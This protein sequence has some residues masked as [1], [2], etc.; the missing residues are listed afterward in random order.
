MMNPNEIKLR[1]F[2]D[3]KVLIAELVRLIDRAS[4]EYNQG[5]ARA[6]ALK[7]LVPALEELKAAGWEGWEPVAGYG[8]LIENLLEV[9]NRD[10]VRSKAVSTRGTFRRYL[11][12]SVT[13]LMQECGLEPKATK[14]GLFENLSEVVLEACGEPVGGLHR[15][16][17]D[18]KKNLKKR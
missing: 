15:I 14:Y 7:K 13:V 9:F 11:V 6:K 1:R 12:A 17:R 10:L 18:V 4:V 8:P 2:T 3:N 16:A 5:R